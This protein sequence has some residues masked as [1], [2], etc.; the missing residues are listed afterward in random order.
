MRLSRLILPILTL[1]CALGIAQ[2][3]DR[4]APVVQV[5]DK[6]VTGYELE[7]RIRFMTLL[8][9]PGD[10]EEE[11]LKA[12]IDERLQVE[13]ATRMGMVL[14]PEQILAGEE[15]FAGRAN[16]NREQFIEAL[17]AA[18]VEEATFRD[19]VT[20]G[21]LWREVVRQRFASRAA[22]SDAEVD[23]ALSDTAP[24]T[25]GVRVLF[26]EI[27]LPANTPAAAAESQR[28]ALEIGQIT[29]FDAFSRAARTYSISP[30]RGR[31]GRVDWLE[32]ENLQPGLA[33]ILLALAPGQVSEPL[34]IPDAIALFQLRAIEDG[35]APPLPNMTVEYAEFL[36][37]GGRSAE[38][39][40]RAAKIERE[41]DNCND[42]FAEAR[43]QPPE[44]MERYTA[45]L[46]DVP[47]DIAR[48]LA[49]LDDGEISTGLVRG[50][51]LVVLMLC[52]RTID[53]PEDLTRE[54][55]RNQLQ[56]QRLASY[57]EGYLAELRASAILRYP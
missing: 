46:A 37:P 20:A 22:V 16:L 8:R 57:A 34:P 26:S 52:S 2:A 25:G 51:N 47:G 45:P 10:V 19:F 29:S 27:I 48:E 13:T 40:A 49:S 11:A 41:T 36:L 21:L 18:G 12:L 38:T 15:E 28:R 50:G 14:S 31:G 3:Q 42:L 53:L 9:Q 24:K 33:Q 44:R 30:S 5:N 35:D 23:R 32:L 7:Q 4:F 6:V 1:L 56:S 43:G 17:A 39:L 54:D 55:V